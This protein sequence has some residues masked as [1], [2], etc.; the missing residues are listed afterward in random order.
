MLPPGVSIRPELP[1]DMS[2]DIHRE[3]KKPA[4]ITVKKGKKP[5]G[6]RKT[7]YRSFPTMSATKWNRCCTTGRYDCGSA[8]CNLSIPSGKQPEPAVLAGTI[9]RVSAFRLLTSLGL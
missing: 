4:E 2:V 8:N 5:G 3:G 1:D 7:I 6:R 9:L